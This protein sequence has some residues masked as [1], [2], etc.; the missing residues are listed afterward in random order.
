MGNLSK[1]QKGVL[2]TCGKTKK[3]RRF[4]PKTPAFIERLFEQLSRF[5][6]LHPA[7]AKCGSGVP[8]ETRVSLSYARRRPYAPPFVFS[9]FEVCRPKKIPKS[10]IFIQKIK[11]QPLSKAK[12]RK[13]RHTDNSH[14][15]NH[16][17]ITELP[18]QFRHELEIH[19]VDSSDHGQWQHDR[20][21]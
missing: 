14:D 16:Q 5:L 2:K 15:E 11:L 18:I 1:R 7:C 12:V 13:H 8:P 3:C 4:P 17:R 10:E 19:A 9:H 6:P 21:D 20:R